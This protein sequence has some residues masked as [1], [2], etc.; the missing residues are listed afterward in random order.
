MLATWG[1][2]WEKSAA[3][4]DRVSGFPTLERG[5]VSSLPVFF[6]IVWIATMAPFDGFIGKHELRIDDKGRLTMPARF[7]AVLRENYADDGNQVV[8]RLSLDMNL[9]VEPLTEYEKV[10]EKF[11]EYDDLDEDVRRLKEVI[12]GQAAREKIDAGG[13]IRLG[14]DLRDI[15]GLDREVTLVGGKRSFTIW[16]RETWKAT[17]AATLHDLKRLA[18][19]VRQ[20]HKKD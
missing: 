11:E 4:W 17:E 7:K 8:V 1:T 9:I 3:K 16:N 12:T 2:M 19:Q 15:A 6:G 20:K 14:A 18:V 13:R 5:W 10:S